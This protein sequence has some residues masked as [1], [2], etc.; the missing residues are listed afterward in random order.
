MDEG[1]ESFASM[2]VYFYAAGWVKALKQPL[3]SISGQF[4]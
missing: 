2:D 3:D 4:S 1:K